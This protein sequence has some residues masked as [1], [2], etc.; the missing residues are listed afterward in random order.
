M[1]ETSRTCLIVQ[2]IHQAGLDLLARGGLMLRHLKQ[3]DA[4]TLVREASDCVAVVTRS[5]GFPAAAIEVAPALRVI[6]SH[7]VGVDAIDVPL[8]TARGIA[9]VNAPHSNV[10]AVAE[11]A[12]ALIFALA[13]SLAAADRATRAGDF[14]FKYR[15]RLV[16]LEGLTLGIVGFGSI[17]RQTA[18]L[19]KALGLKVIAHSLETALEIYA[20]IG[21]EPVADLHELLSRSDIVSLHLPLTASTKELIGAAELAAM[22][23]GSFLVNTGRGG[24]V[25]EMALIDALDNSPLAGAG[26]DVFASE[27]M[28]AD[29]PLLHHPRLLLTPHIAGSTE[30]SLARTAEDVARGVLALLAGERPR[31]LVN[32]AV[33]PQRRGART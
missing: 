17:G 9:V 11:H 29:H 19:A 27:H 32:P 3:A 20:E 30:A 8:A 26:L 7:G 4:Q 14:G 6:G 21:V 31:F 18:V 13:K 12:I 23:P 15:T 33:W 2:P 5:A 22:R 24:V 16:E 1:V 10:R 25:D 28:P